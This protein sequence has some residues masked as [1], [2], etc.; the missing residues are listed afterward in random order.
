MTKVSKKISALTRSHHQ[1]GWSSEVKSERRWKISENCVMRSQD[2]QSRVGERLKKFET[3]EKRKIS[4]SPWLLSTLVPFRAIVSCQHFYTK[5]QRNVKDHEMHLNNH[6]FLIT[7]VRAPRDRLPLLSWLFFCAEQER[8]VGSCLIE[9]ERSR[10]VFLFRI[11][12]FFRQIFISSKM[13]TFGRRE[14]CAK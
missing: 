4:W 10:I 2:S 7:H 8:R 13:F 14:E 9:L 5:N 1:H 3:D 12:S 11:I 6:S